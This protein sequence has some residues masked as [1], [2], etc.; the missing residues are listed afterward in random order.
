MR[1][2]TTELAQ[3]SVSGYHFLI[4]FI[5]KKRKTNLPRKSLSTERVGHL[6]SSGEGHRGYT[7]FPLLAFA[8]SNFAEYVLACEKG[9]AFLQGIRQYIHSGC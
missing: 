8:L 7:K 2:N 1:Q 5:F 4:H 3:R 9:L 6:T